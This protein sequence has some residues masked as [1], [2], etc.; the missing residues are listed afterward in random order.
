LSE[1]RF[2]LTP[3]LSL[4]ERGNHLPRCDE[5]RRAGHLS[6]GRRSP[7]SPRERVGVRGKEISILERS[8]R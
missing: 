7:L 1:H 8:L 6:D 2:P 3:T 5:S 4:G